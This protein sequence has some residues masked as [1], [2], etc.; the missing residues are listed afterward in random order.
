MKIVFD[1]GHGGSDPGAVGQIYKEKDLTLE[2]CNKVKTKLDV[3]LTRSTDVYVSLSA[4]GLMAKNGDLFVSVH[5]NAFNSTATGCEVFYSVDLPN[6]KAYA[7]KI[8]SDLSKAL[9]IPDRGAK[10]RESIKYPGEDYYTVIDTAQDKKCK[11]VFLVE[12]GFISNPIEE[13]KMDTSIIADVLV[14]NSKYIVGD[15]SGDDTLLKLGSEGPE[16]VEL[17]QVLN[18]I[19]DFGLDVDGIF[20]PKTEEAVKFAQKDL[21]VTVDGIVGPITRQ[22]LEDKLKAI[23]EKKYLIMELQKFLNSLGYK[24]AD[25]KELVVDGIKGTNTNY[26]LDEFLK[27]IE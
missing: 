21:G 26:A 8:S 23:E 9:G 3:I 7:A 20:G 10:T 15:S 27:D 12:C 2:V 1:P 18:Q 5:F 13:K 17:Q 14:V 11:H 19:Y 16:V 6:D 24:G 4:R 25:G 22:A